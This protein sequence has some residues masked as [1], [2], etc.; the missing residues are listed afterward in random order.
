[1]AGSMGTTIESLEPQLGALSKERAVLADRLVPSGADTSA[2]RR[3]SVLACLSV[4]RS[5]SAAAATGYFHGRDPRTLRV[6]EA[7]AG[8][9]EK[10]RRGR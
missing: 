6:E 7:D 10:G 8:H 4:S 2:Q 5:W 1:M 3:L 9:P